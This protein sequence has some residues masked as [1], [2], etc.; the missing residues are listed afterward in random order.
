MAPDW[1][2]LFVAAFVVVMAVALVLQLATLIGLLLAVKKL[3]VRIEQTLDKKVEPLLDSAKSVLDSAR[4][5]IEEAREQAQRLAVTLDEAQE[6]A[7]TQLTRIDQLLT[8]ASDRARLEII[9][10]DELVADTVHRVEQTT[11]LIQKSVLRPVKEMQAVAIGILAA[12]QVL[13]RRG[14]FRSTPERATQDEEMF[15]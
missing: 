6:M 2:Y 8:E 11:D 15:I 7:R 5:M 14:G 1:F 9:R 3:Q 13:L 4:P 12:V 10:V